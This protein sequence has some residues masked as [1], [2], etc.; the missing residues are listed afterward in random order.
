MGIMRILSILWLICFILFGFYAE[1][2]PQD[3]SDTQIANAIYKTENS[4]KYPYGIRSIDTNGNE[5]YARKLCLNS[6]RNAR[7][8]WIEAGKP[9]DFITHMGKR[10]CP[11]TAHPKNVNWVR[12]VKYF[13][14]KGGD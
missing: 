1:A 13:L 6:I 11:P 4:T 3:Y 10:Y 14:Q 12:L 2:H 8:R 5:A 7:K 9:E